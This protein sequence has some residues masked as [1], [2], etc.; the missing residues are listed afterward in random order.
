MG[1][2]SPGA[3][4]RLVLEDG[5]RAFAKAVGPE[6]N[7]DSP[8]IYRDEARIAERL[9]A[10]APVP[11]LL[12]WFEDAGWVLLLFEDIDGTMPAQ[13]WVRDELDR[14]LEALASLAA[15]L[16]PAPAGVDAPPIGQRLG[17]DF[18]GWRALTAASR[19]GEDL[20]GLDP[21][22][23]LHL[24]ELAGLEARWERAAAG[25]SLVHADLR[26]DNLLLTAD[27]VYV[28]DWPWACTAQPWVDLLGMLPSVAMQGGPPP[29]EIF[30]AHPVTRAAAA[31]A[32][33]AVI[34]ALAGFFVHNSRRPPPPGIPGVREFQ[35]AQG[36][37]AL[38]W[39][40]ERT[41]WH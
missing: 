37:V 38:S 21:W 8:G 26:A 6:L 16:T 27:R 22:A 15:V 9:P 14:V 17:A 32:A 3:A 13:P 23:R 19:D 28:V 10:G 36:H 31:A 34:A 4:A 2:F 39:L 5:R 30:S 18:R 35:R 25:G 1:G 11:R 20:A 33:T 7:P 24:T 12:A 29:E 40:R 41:G